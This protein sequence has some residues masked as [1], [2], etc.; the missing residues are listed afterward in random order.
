MTIN[1]FNTTPFLR[2]T[3]QFPADLPQ[4]IV[5]INRAYIDI[6]E[7]VNNR[8]ISTFSLNKSA[9]TGNS[10]F[11]KTNKQQSQRQMYTFTA[12]GNIA[13]GLDFNRIDR[14]IDGY[15]TYTNGTNY[16]G[17]TFGTSVAVAGIVTFYVTSTNIVVLSGAGAPAITSGT[18]IIEWIAKA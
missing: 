12:A 10:Y 14:F 11:F 18:I 3:R 17:V 6:A 4:L 8:T 1:S 5:E 13:H 9:V 2:Q 16:F 7:A 15:G